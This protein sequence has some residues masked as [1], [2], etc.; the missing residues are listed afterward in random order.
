M[1]LPTKGVPPG[2]ALISLG[3]DIL[4]LLTET[5]TAIGKR[6]ARV[7]KALATLPGVTVTIADDVSYAGG[8]ALP[9]SE[10]PTKVIRLEARGLTAD[11]LAAKLR[12]T[13]PP[14]ITRIAK[15]A[16]TLDLRTV[17]SR[18]TRLLLAALRAA[19]A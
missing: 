3:A 15:D 14:V 19:L 17:P 9:M 6:A 7:A 5:K 10:L 12:S 16:V 2:R 18:D 11:R 1:I 8:G 13:R 4:R